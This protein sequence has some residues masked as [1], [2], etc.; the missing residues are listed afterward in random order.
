MPQGEASVVYMQ[1]C[2]LRVPLTPGSI[3]VLHGYTA[4]FIKSQSK[5]QRVDHRR[6]SMSQ[7]P[8]ARVYQS[9]ERNSF[10]LSVQ[11]GDAQQPWFRHTSFTASERITTSQCGKDSFEAMSV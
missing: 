7:A 3:F 6:N 2:T 10:S 8:S 5:I 9:V 1:S 11:Y 4:R